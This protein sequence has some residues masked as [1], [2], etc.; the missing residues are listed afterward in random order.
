MLKILLWEWSVEMKKQFTDDEIKTFIRRTN[1][2]L[3]IQDPLPVLQDL[4]IEYKEIGNDSYRINVRNQKTPSAFISLKNGVWKYK[5]WGD[6]TRGG[7]IIN[8]VMELTNKPYKEALNYSLHTLG[9]KNYLNEALERKGDS[10]ALSQT[11]RER[12]KAQKEANMSREAS[13][14]LSRVTG[15]YE[16]VT[17]K[18]AI[19][20]LAARGIVKIPPHL[21][22][23]S[24]EYSLKNGELKKVF[25]VGVL[26]QDGKSADIHFLK[27]I[28]DLKTMSFGAKKDISFFKNP[29]STKVAVFESKM[30]YAAAYQQMPLDNVNIIIAN[31]SSNASKAAELLKKENLTEHVMIFNQNDIAGYKFTVQ[32]A[33]EAGLE[34][35]KS[36][37]YDILTEYKT[38]IN[39]LLLKGERIADRI[40][41]TR[42]LEYFESIAN[43]L[44]SI[45]KAQKQ[46]PITITKE[47]IQMANQP[48]SQERER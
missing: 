34:S 45:Q 26:T 30:D 18:L 28:G 24:G 1:E 43:S 2:D 23:I 35:F 48:Q 27:P 8:V 10:F 4:G 9:V 44:E 33:R 39:D 31:S 16:V 42:G 21:K 41:A 29:N 40:E 11:D 37:R 22:I 12:I 32:I 17:N 47:D 7:N 5:D 46:P 6:E 3:V 38:D 19:D 25:G 20:Y 15:V 13:H 36:I 14:P